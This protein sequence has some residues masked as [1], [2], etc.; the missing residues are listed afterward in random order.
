MSNKVLIDTHAHLQFKSFQEDLD[1]VLG[2]VKEKNTIVNLIGTQTDMSK[3]AVELAEKYDFLY[4]TVGLHPIHEKKVG[5]K[6][7]EVEFVSRGED[8]D[9]NFYEQF[10]THEKVIA[11]GET[12]L[13]LFHIPKDVSIDQILRDQKEVFLKH[14]NLAK[15]YDLPL[16]MHVRDAHVHMAEMLGNL[17]EEINGVVHCFTGNFEDAKKYLDLGLYLGFTGVITFPPKKLNPKPQEELLKVIKEIPMDK[18]LVETDAPFLAPQ[19]YRGERAES[20]MVEEM[21][22]KIAEIKGKTYEEVREKS[23]ENALRLFNKIKLSTV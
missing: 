19:K 7:E 1:E 22:V 9:E 15:K 21:I 2:R 4:A 3:K 23:V 11:L 14:Y 12:G 20:W 8:F 16:V 13:D 10:L 17:N 5:V 6:E 18:F